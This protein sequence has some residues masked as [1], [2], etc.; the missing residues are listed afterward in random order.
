MEQWKTSWNNG[1]F[2]NWAT[3]ISMK[4]PAASA[5]RHLMFWARLAL[6]IR[7]ADIEWTYP[8][9]VFGVDCAARFLLYADF[10]LV[11]LGRLKSVEITAVLNSESFF[12]T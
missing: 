11:E 4:D 7:P 5:A 1:K 9:N 12:F 2:Q 8:L 3:R 10:G 6:M